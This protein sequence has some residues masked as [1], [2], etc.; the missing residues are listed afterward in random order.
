[1]YI[2]VYMYI[3]TEGAG[4]ARR[5]GVRTARWCVSPGPATRP[6]ERDTTGYEPFAR[7]G[8]EVTSPSR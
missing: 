4:G 6:P 8:Q 3:S 1:M 5:S 2:Y 7:E